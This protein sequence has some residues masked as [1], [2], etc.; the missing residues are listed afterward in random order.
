MKSK[1]EVPHEDYLRVQAALKTHVPYITMA[2]S[3]TGLNNSEFNGHQPTRVCCQEYVFDDKN[4]EYIPGIHFDKLVKCSAQ[5]LNAALSNKDYDVFAQGGIDRAAYMSGQGVLEIDDFR[6]G[7]SDFLKGTEPHTTFIAN[8]AR[9]CI[10]MLD[11]IG[12]ADFIKEKKDAHEV[13]DQPAL[14]RAFFKEHGLDA[15]AGALES[16]RDYIDKKQDN[17]EKI[18]GVDNRCK[19]MGKFVEYCGREKSILISQEEATFNRIANTYLEDASERGREKYRNSTVD[20]KLT[21]LIAS[22]RLDERCKERDFD[23]DLNHFYNILDGK[24]KAK[25]IVIMHCATTD[26]NPPLVPIQFSASVYPIENGRMTAVPETKFSMDIEADARSVQKALARRDDV[27]PRKKFDAFKFTGIDYEHA[28]SQGKMT[29][30]DGQVSE[31][32]LFSEKKAAMGINSF[33]E[34]YSPTEYPIITISKDKEGKRGFAQAAVAGL[35][36]LPVVDAPS[37]DFSQ[38]IKEYVYCAHNDSDYDKNVLFDESKDLNKFGGFSFKDIAIA[39]NED[40]DP[41]SAHVGMRCAL[42]GKWLSSISEQHCEIEAQ[43]NHAR[44]E[45][46]TEIEPQQSDDKAKNVEQAVEQGSPSTRNLS[47]EQGR[48]GQGS[49]VQIPESVQKQHEPEPVQLELSSMKSTDHT[50]TYKDR[51]FEGEYPGKYYSGEELFAEE[52]YDN[53]VEA[54]NDLPQQDVTDINK[55]ELDVLRSNVEG[56]YVEREI[57][58]SRREKSPVQ[59]AP[60]SSLRPQEKSIENASHTVPER[61]PPASQVSPDVAAL[62]SVMTAQTNAMSAHIAS[63]STQMA[64]LITQNQTLINAVVLQSRA[65][66]K[67]LENTIE[68]ISDRSTEKSTD[69]QHEHSDRDST[70]IERLEQ[71]KEEIAGIFKELPMSSGAAKDLLKNANELISKGQTAMD[72]EEIQEKAPHKN[73]KD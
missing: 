8:N 16:L 25:G 37:I 19:L 29:T 41:N 3:S 59:D 17:G 73:G 2:V 31:K 11:T 51:N 64:S 14:T 69:K 70:V 71:V 68:I 32:A 54:V 62:I 67:T 35:G 50:P 66:T 43:K 58:K 46:Q 27:N 42:I 13:L 12:C 52:G 15:K 49:A 38:L 28:Y 61:L 57:F 56:E 63:V 7:F 26:V 60:P 48:A 10:E 72:K 65:L 53:I 33:F 6:K 24:T 40:I 30:L 34:R 36:N 45:K 22:N 5:A 1:F 20:D 39:N 23:C 18:V 44:S 47:I 55:D 9:F 21:T 4:E